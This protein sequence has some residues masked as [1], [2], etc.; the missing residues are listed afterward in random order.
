MKAIAGAAAALRCYTGLPDDQAYAEALEKYA[1]CER[2]VELE[3][4]MLARL[5]ARVPDME[6]AN[7]KIRAANNRASHLAKLLERERTENR[8]RRDRLIR[9]RYGPAAWDV[10]AQSDLQAAGAAD[11]PL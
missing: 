11:E 10:S 6:A 5:V 4:A 2:N 1:F 9:E 8:N 3:L 7:N